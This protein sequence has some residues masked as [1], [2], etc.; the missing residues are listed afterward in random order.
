M[1]DFDRDFQ[2][3][4][5]QYAKNMNDRDTLKSVHTSIQ[6]QLSDLEASKKK[7]ED[8]REKLTDV[9]QRATV[10]AKSAKSFYVKSIG[11]ILLICL[12]ILFGTSIIP[13]DCPPPFEYIK[14]GIILTGLIASVTVLVMSIRVDHREFLAENEAIFE[15]ALLEEKS[16]NID[17]RYKRLMVL[18]GAVS[19]QIDLLMYKDIYNGV[20]SMQ[21]WLKENDE[22]GFQAFI[23]AA[24]NCQIDLSKYVVENN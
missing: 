5:E 3:I 24:K 21:E 20:H 10:A 15:E 13:D 8:R 7:L 22:Q 2:L 9:K 11:F 14:A 23:N 1:K 18:L 4:A 16:K 6:S 17:E 19:S 12:F